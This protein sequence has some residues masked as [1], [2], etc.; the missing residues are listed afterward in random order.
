MSTT[1]AITTIPTPN[2]VALQYY[3]GKTLVLDLD[4]TLVHSVR[5]GSETISSVSPSIIHKTIEVQC[6]KQSLL[7]EVYK[8]PHVD[9]FLKTISQWYKI[10][11]YTASMAE[12]ADP[13]IDWLDQDN[14]ISQRF[15]RQSCVARNG[16]FLKDITLAEN[17]LNKVCLIDNSTVAFDLFKENGIALPT[18]ISNPNDESLLD[19]LP[20]LDALRFA[21]DVRSILRLQHK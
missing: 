8:R 11:I 17:D 14:I 3:K 10:V 5:L 13:V 1:F 2:S 20:F 15:F 9:F 7:Y 12:Y 21:A 6:D 19:L 4:E 18:W 16:N